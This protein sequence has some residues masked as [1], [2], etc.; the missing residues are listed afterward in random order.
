VNQVLAEVKKNSQTR[1]LAVTQSDP[2]PVLRDLASIGP[3]F[4]EQIGAFS[5]VKIDAGS[6]PN[7][8]IITEPLFPNVGL[9]LDDGNAIRFES[10]QS[11]GIPFDPFGL[12]TYWFGI[13]I[14]GT[15]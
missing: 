10:Y 11:I 13:L 12:H 9:V 6:I 1:I 7:Y 3:F 15:L 2:R 4:F 5:D 14:A 8:Q